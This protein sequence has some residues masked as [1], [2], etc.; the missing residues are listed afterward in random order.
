M[1]SAASR[2]HMDRVASNGCVLC[3]RLG[4]GWSAAEVHHA[5]AGVGAAQRNSDWM[6]IGL[7]HEHHRGNT[8]IHGLGTRAFERTYDVT[9]LQLVAETLEAIYG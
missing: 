5:R 2:R 7:C 9:E 3:N 1:S 6:T 8:G 4:Y